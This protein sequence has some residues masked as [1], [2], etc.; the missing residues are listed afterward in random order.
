LRKLA[1]A[2]AFQHASHSVAHFRTDYCRSAQDRSELVRQALTVGHEHLLG[3]VCGGIDAWAAAGHPTESIPVVGPEGMAQTVLDVRQ[4]GEWQTGHL[5]GALH[6][7]LG[8][9]RAMPL[10]DGPVTVMCGHGER[11]M[12]AA[13]ILASRGHTRLTVLDGGPDDWQRSAG[14]ALDSGR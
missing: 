11:A 7:E 14:R 2:D 1:R 8:A 4:D 3:E 6:V 9:V 10:P 13:S 5:P 12:T